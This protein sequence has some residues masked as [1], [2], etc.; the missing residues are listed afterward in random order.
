ME[1]LRLGVEL[2]PLLTPQQHQ[3]RAMSVT[4]TIA[5]GNTRSLTH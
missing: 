2:V 1:I 5:H 4:H 3:I